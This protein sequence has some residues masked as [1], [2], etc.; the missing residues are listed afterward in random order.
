LHVAHEHG[1]AALTGSLSDSVGVGVF[2]LGMHRSGTSAVTRLISLLGLGTPPEEDLVQPT[3]KNP[4]GYWES[5]ALVNFNERVLAA[6]G[7]HMGCPVALEPGWENDPRLDSLRADAPRA[8]GEIFPVTPWVWKDPRHCLAFAFWR[9]VLAVKPVVVLVNRNPLEITASAQR[10]RNEQGKIY[11]LALWERYLREALG[12]VAGLP[13][14]VTNYSDV[15]S[16]P[17]DWSARTQAFLIGSGVPARPSAED[18]VLAFVDTTLR[19]TSFDRGDLLRDPDVSEAQR[20]LSSALNDIEGGYASFSPPPL[21]DETP[22]TEALLTERR[23]AVELKRQ[24]VLERRSSWRW[25]IRSSRYAAPARPIYA[26]GRRL[27]K[28]LQGH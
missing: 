20:A 7:C 18:E 17:I 12:Q 5:E 2:V 22:T 23:R 13:V 10:V 3:D 4:K 27:L 15:L 1:S 26:R 28:T 16:G 14:L 9:S 11:T 8:V 25:R 6:V 19:H 24:L 21:P